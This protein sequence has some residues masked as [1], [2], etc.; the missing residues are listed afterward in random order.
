MAVQE[1]F[2]NAELALAA[3]AQLDAALSVTDQISK[4]QDAGM[5]ERQARE[6]AARYPEVITTFDDT[7]TGFDA[8]VFRSAGGDACDC[9]RRS[10]REIYTSILQSRYEN[11]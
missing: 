11:P 10:A 3:Y 8:T 1:L 4:L 5:S 7:E 9:R 6:F 2:N